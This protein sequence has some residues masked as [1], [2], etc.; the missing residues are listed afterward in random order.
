LASLGALQVLAVLLL[1]LVFGGTS[2][3]QPDRDCLSRVP[4]LLPA[5]ALQFPM[6]KLVHDALDGFLLRFR[7]MSFHERTLAT[8][9]LKID[10]SAANFGY[11]PGVAKNRSALRRN[12]WRSGTVG[13]GGNHQ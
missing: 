8:L 12:R 6:L 5:A 2:L 3:V 13:T 7:L 4:D 11:N 9:D 10:R 1:A